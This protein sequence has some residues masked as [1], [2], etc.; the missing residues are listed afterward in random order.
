MC[1]KP[2]DLRPGRRRIS[3]FR[4]N[5]RRIK[6]TLPESKFP[7]AACANILACTTS[8]LCAERNSVNDR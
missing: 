1:I 8:R 6:P 4:S 3:I 2:C 7:T 5:I